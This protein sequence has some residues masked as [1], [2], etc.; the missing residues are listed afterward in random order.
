MTRKRA[1]HHVWNWWIATLHA[2][3][4]LDIHSRDG[5]GTSAQHHKVLTHVTE[6]RYGAAQFGQGG[7]RGK[8]RQYV[9]SV[10]ESTM[11]RFDDLLL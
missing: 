10:Q 2:G 3:R 6:G 11:R 1:T 7:T 8:D 4:Y 5:S 9:R